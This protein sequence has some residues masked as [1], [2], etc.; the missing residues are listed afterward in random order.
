MTTRPRGWL[1]K[2]PR[3]EMQKKSQGNKKIEQYQASV[4]QK[5]EALYQKNGLER[6]AH[7]EARSVVGGVGWPSFSIDTS[8]KF[9]G[10]MNT[11][12]DTEAWS[13][14]CDYHSRKDEMLTFRIAS[15]QLPE[16]EDLGHRHRI[17]QCHRA[18]VLQC[19]PG[20]IAR[21]QQTRALKVK[22]QCCYCCY[23]YRYV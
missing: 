5:K 7:S 1:G 22:R 19:C 11:G 4:R 2:V 16:I 17:S 15:R 23:R 13:K 6:R 18:T 8:V 9:C 14:F 21:V 12:F 10:D 3:P 20:W